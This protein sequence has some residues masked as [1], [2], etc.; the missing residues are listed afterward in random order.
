MADNLQ[1]EIVDDSADNDFGSFGGQEGSTTSA[2]DVA[3]TSTSSDGSGLSG[4]QAAVAAAPEPADPN[5]GAASRRTPPVDAVAASPWRGVKEAAAGLGYR[6]G[7]D[8]TDDNQALVNL[9]QRANT[10]QQS[11][12]Y[13]QLGR[14]LAPHAPKLQQFLASQQ[15]VAPVASPWD[16]PEWDQRWAQIVTRDDLTGVYVGKPGVPPEI[17]QKVNAYAEWVDRREND[18]E[19]YHSHV[20]EK[21]F[22]KK[23]AEQFERRSREAEQTAS[24]NAIHQA[25]AGWLYQH[26]DQGQMVR[27]RDGRPVASPGGTRYLQHVRSVASM[28]VTDPRHQDYLARQSLTAEILTAQQ[29][30]N[31]A[32]VAQSAN[33]RTIQAQ[34]QPNRNVLGSLPAQD[35]QAQPAAVS[36]STNGLSLADV[37][38]RELAGYTDADFQMVS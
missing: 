28:G 3:E 18:P 21:V 22:E 38:R 34:T 11:D 25:N 33:P 1:A 7:D 35:R 14:Q 36:A 24:I 4:T 16:K 17:V 30:Q 9:V 32:A 15:Q 5:L 13:S 27:G 10:A 6:F 29:T 31:S 12:Y 19:G 2:A 20:A 8:V 37:M 23:F 26:D